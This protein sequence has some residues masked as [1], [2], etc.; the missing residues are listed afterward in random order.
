MLRCTRQP[1]L[2]S[3]QPPCLSTN[4]MAP[5]SARSFGIMTGYCGTKAV[6]KRREVAAKQSGSRKRRQQSN[7]AAQ[8][9]AALL[10]QGPPLHTHNTTPSSSLAR[11]WCSRRSVGGQ[12]RPCST[13]S[14]TRQQQQCSHTFSTHLV[15]QA[16]RGEPGPVPHG[17]EERRVVQ[18]QQLHVLR[19]A[20]MSGSRAA[21][22]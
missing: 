22:A 16:Q 12:T 2:C 9:A 14:G 6:G 8:A 10:G 21:A 19:S 17:E 5:V 13:Q 20:A 7:Q 11:T 3:A 15:Q 1:R 18:H 4:F